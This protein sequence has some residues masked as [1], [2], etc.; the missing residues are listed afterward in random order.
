MSRLRDAQ[1]DHVAAAAVQEGQM[2]IGCVDDGRRAAKTVVPASVLGSNHGGL[3]PSVRAIRGAGQWMRAVRR[4]DG[5]PVGM[6]AV[7]RD[8]VSSRVSTSSVVSRGIT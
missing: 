3:N 1:R 6:G 7:I 4:D 8:S 2:C 5:R